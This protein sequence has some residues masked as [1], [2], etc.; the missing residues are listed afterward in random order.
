[1]GKSL[2][3]WDVNELSETVNKDEGQGTCSKIHPFLT[4]C[5]R[6]QKDTRLHCP[7]S[8]QSSPAGELGALTETPP[9]AVPSFHASVALGSSWGLMHLTST[10]TFRCKSF[11]LSFVE[12]E[13]KAQSD[14]WTLVKLHCIPA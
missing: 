6:L 2:Y 8:L 4:A 13:S 10:V 11:L 5:Y 12:W 1:M 14:Q 3:P 9:S 7:S